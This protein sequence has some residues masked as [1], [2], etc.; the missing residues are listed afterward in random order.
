MSMSKQLLHSTCAGSRVAASVALAFILTTSTSFASP[1]DEA[2]KLSVQGQ[3]MA[4]KS[5]QKIEQL[6]DNTRKMLLEYRNLQAR[7]QGL[8]AH[9][10]QLEARVQ[11]DNEKIA[12]LQSELEQINVSRGEIAPMLQQMFTA[13]E[14]LVDNDLPF[15]KPMRQ[16]QLK[17][18][19]GD[20]GDAGKPLN[21]HLDHL[22][23]VY[24]KE[25][26][27]GN[28]L[29]GWQAPLSD[30]PGSQTVNFLRLGRIALY[31]QSL[32][33]S[34][35]AWWDNHRKNWQMLDESATG[36]LAEAIRQA[37]TKTAPAFV[38]LPISSRMEACC[39]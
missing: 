37:N 1:V 14:Q 8:E 26:G 2:L 35:S 18:L 5:Q 17:E 3:R 30:E 15:Q 21:Q 31:Y 29:V 25:Y 16:Q 39:S 28:E 32:D 4:K 33:G 36:L 11:Q 7:I 27:Y 13:L 19:K 6:D 34:K 23:Q 9:N 20:L 24:E 22:L 38:T 12:L 10:S